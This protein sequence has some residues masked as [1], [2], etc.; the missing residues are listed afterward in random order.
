MK[1]G[2]AKDLASRG[3]GALTEEQYTAPQLFHRVA[4]PE[5]VAGLIAYLL[6]DESRF[7]TKVAYEISGGFAG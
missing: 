7:I 5:E 4:Q 1:A 3:M 6:S 2:H